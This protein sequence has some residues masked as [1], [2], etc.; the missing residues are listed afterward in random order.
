MS[1]HHSPLGVLIPLLAPTTCW[2]CGCSCFVC[3]CAALYKCPRGCE[4]TPQVHIHRSLHFAPCPVSV[5]AG[6]LRWGGCSARP[7]QRSSCQQVTCGNIKL[8]FECCSVPTSLS[9]P[10]T[11]LYTSFILLFKL[12]HP[13]ISKVSWLEGELRGY[14]NEVIPTGLGGEAGC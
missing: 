2:K 10:V 4:S 14:P 8:G 11:N 6:M 12:N 3:T 1:P 13:F 5:V 9:P 7:R